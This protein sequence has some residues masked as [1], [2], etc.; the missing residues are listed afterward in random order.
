MRIF[1]EK[2]LELFPMLFLGISAKNNLTTR[3]IKKITDI[4]FEY[5]H[6]FPLIAKFL[7]EKYLIQINSTEKP[8]N[9]NSFL[10]FCEK[11]IYSKNS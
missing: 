5:S 7:L 8:I 3:E 11:E 4:L 2:I 10:I 1:T 9:H 6:G